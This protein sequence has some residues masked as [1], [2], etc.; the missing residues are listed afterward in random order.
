[1][2]R[3]VF[4]I[5]QGRKSSF[6]RPSGTPGIIGMHSQGSATLHPGLFSTAPSGSKNTRDDFHEVSR[7]AEPEGQVSGFGGST[8]RFR[9][10]E[11]RALL[12]EVRRIHHQGGGGK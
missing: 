5:Q 2:K 1:M 7:L 6:V 3:F 4:Q 9:A 11:M 10:G 8:G 12:H